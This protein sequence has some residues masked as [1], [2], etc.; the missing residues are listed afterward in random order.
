MVP[1]WQR[2][3]FWRDWPTLHMPPAEM[4]NILQGSW[5]FWAIQASRHK[6]TDSKVG[7]S[8]DRNQ[9]KP[10]QG[11]DLKENNKK[12]EMPKIRYWFSKQF[13]QTCA[14]FRLST[15]IPAFGAADSCGNPQTL[16]LLFHFGHRNR[17]SIDLREPVSSMNWW[18]V[19]RS[20]CNLNGWLQS[21][22][23]I[24]TTNLGGT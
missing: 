7:Y 14:G 3:A 18:P 24:A 15:E 20:I 1:K 2:H 13:S 6:L 8:A 4:L 12:P 11:T 19:L 17:K 23:P 9:S 16:A 21:Q 22:G 10:L 5:A